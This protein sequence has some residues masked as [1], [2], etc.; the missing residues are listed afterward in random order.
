MG[1]PLTPA[2]VPLRGEGERTVPEAAETIEAQL[3]WLLD[4]RRRAVLIPAGTPLPEL[5]AGAVCAFPTRLGLFVFQGHRLSPYDI[6]R[7]I[8]DDTLGELLGYGIPRKPEGASDCVVVRGPDGREKQAV[9]TDEATRPAV[10]AA[11]AAVAD[12]GDT[13]TREAA[14]SILKERCDELARHEL[15]LHRYRPEDAQE[16]HDLAVA[17]PDSRLPHHPTWVIRRH[18][19]LVGA[20]GINSLPLFHLWLPVSDVTSRQCHD[21]LKHVENTYRL[22][23]HPVVAAIIDVDCASYPLAPRHGYF[24]LPDERLFLKQL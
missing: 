1:S 5:P 10:E 18:G 22:A 17:E 3:K 6:I 9:V 12:P 19:K 4:G 2:R 24:E 8:K 20:V 15:T 14:T 7:H 13:I 16:L 23:E 11:A 21:V